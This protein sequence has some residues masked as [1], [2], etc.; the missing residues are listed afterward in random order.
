MITTMFIL[1]QIPTW[2]L[3]KLSLHSYG[4]DDDHL[5][6]LRNRGNKNYSTC[7]IIRRSK[8]CISKWNKAHNKIQI[9]LES[10]FNTI[11][12]RTKSYVLSPNNS[13]FALTYTSSV[14][15]YSIAYVTPT[16]LAI[17]QHHLFL[18]KNSPFYPFMIKPHHQVDI[19]IIKYILALNRQI[20]IYSNILFQ[21]YSW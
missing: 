13:V 20:F 16:S 21:Y 10:N 5:N 17:K 2:G 6:R 1:K 18:S 4:D 15:S 7:R 12:V 19:I 8:K 11:A 9:K 14:L 3:Q